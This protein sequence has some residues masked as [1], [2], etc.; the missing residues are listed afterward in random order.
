MNEQLIY[1][2]I[3]DEIK[4]RIVSGT[5]PPGGRLPT[6]RDLVDEFNT[7]RLTVAKSL[8]SLI[9]D[10]YIVR[11][12]GRGT[13]VCDP[14]PS[15]GS[16]IRRDTNWVHFISPGG[17]SGDSIRH[18]LLEG[19][20]DAMTPLGF[21]VG[22]TFYNTVEE[23][24]SLLRSKGA[25]CRGMA[26]WPA[27][28]AAVEAELRELRRKGVP[29]VLV[30]SYFPELAADYVISANSAGAE[31]M[32]DHL[33]A[34][35]HRRISYLTVQPD[36]VSLSDRLS[37]VISAFGRH[38]IA[39]GGNLG[40]I[41]E[42]H[43]VSPSSHGAANTEFIRDWLRGELAKPE[44]PSAVFCG[45]DSIA[46]TLLE[47]CGELGLRVPD[48]LSI[49]GFDN[50][51]RSAYL[52]VPLTTVAQDFFEIGRT[53]GKILARLNGRTDDIPMQY[54]IPPKLVVRGSTAPP[55]R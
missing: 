10:G 1:K 16:A 55:E 13:F 19:L 43:K 4:T 17:S 46:I 51:D 25:E 15:I 30:D 33:A 37:G 3:E 36:R 5:Y 22:V 41:P 28:D 45:N 18:G 39:I 12:R 23:Q 29:F 27:R 26:V 24:I 7:S 49:A 14:L 32:I 53:A 34:L 31:A 52:P 42:T 48:A 20:C 21:N 50:I 38:G 35:G 6:E 11:T 40:I 9:A 47:L 8:A 2:R 54:R 44:P